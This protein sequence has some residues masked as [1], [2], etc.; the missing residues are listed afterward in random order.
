MLAT[1][2]RALQTV[3][4]RRAAAAEARWIGKR[5]ARRR[6]RV[7]TKSTQHWLTASAVAGRVPSFP[8]PNGKPLLLGTDVMN[9]CR[10]DLLVVQDPLLDGRQRISGALCGSSGYS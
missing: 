2:Q 3:T 7:W 4:R 9:A 8:T 6:R 1:M 5:A 10:S